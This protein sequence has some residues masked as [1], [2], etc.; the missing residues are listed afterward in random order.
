M[1]WK[2]SEA[3]IARKWWKESLRFIQLVHFFEHYSSSLLIWNNVSESG[4]HSRIMDL[5]KWVEFLLRGYEYWVHWNYCAVKW[6]KNILTHQPLLVTSHNTHRHSLVI[7]GRAKWWRLNQSENLLHLLGLPRITWTSLCHHYLQ[8]KY[9]SSGG[10]CRCVATTATSWTL[11]HHI[12]INTCQYTV[13][14]YHNGPQLILETR[15]M[16]LGKKLYLHLIIFK[17][18]CRRRP[19]MGTQMWLLNHTIYI[20]NLQRITALMNMMIMEF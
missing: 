8:Y 7:Q 18:G 1:T 11:L 13:V 5:P 2:K 3:Y 20:W 10:A 15:N 9:H 17:W 12:S 16:A 4:L 14:L 6:R 19:M